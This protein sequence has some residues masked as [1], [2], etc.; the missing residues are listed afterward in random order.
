[1]MNLRFPVVVLAV[2]VSTLMGTG[3]LA[4]NYGDLV[5]P[6]TGHTVVPGTTIG[7][8]YDDFEMTFTYSHQFYVDFDEWERLG[9]NYRGDTPDVYEAQADF[10][11]YGGYAMQIPARPENEWGMLLKN[12]AGVNIVLKKKTT[13]GIDSLDWSQPQAVKISAEGDRHRAWVNGNLM[14]DVND[15]SNTGSGHITVDSWNGGVTL[16]NIDIIPEPSALI[17]LGM[18]VIGMLSSVRRR[19][20]GQS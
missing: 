14:Y 11:L 15:G 3:A 7:P 18:G 20:R 6:A 16:E 19:C 12:P 1:M 17:L 5:L 4:T 13:L 10:G 8:T 2:A 9:I